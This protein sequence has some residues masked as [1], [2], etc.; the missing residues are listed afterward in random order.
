MVVNQVSAQEE[1]EAIAG[2]VGLV[3]EKYRRKSNFLTLE[4]L[5]KEYALLN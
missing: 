3:L 2:S 4:I 1:G 5:Q